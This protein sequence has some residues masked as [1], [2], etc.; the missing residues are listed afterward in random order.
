MLDLPDDQRAHVQQRLR[1]D[2]VVWLTTVRPDGQPQTSAV[3]FLW[4]GETFLIFSMPNLKVRN[5][6]QNPHVALALD[7][8]RRGGDVITVEGTAT[9]IEDGSMS[10]TYEPYVR[11]YQA[12]ME[13]INL[14]A[15]RMAQ[16]Y[17]VGLRI[18]PT[19]FRT[20]Q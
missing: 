4:D 15:E 13:R 5:L 6:R 10:A 11:K 3:W 1:D 16:L 19:R 2:I 8:T 12:E 7:D 18:T 9:L 14:P 17:S 20:V